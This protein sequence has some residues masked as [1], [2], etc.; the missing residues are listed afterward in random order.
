MAPGALLCLRY[1]ACMAHVKRSN[2]PDEPMGH[3]YG[4]YI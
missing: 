3:L 1:S 2:A 4:L